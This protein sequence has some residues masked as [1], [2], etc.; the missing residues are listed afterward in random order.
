ML[1]TLAA[2]FPL[3]WFG[4]LT[5]SHGAGMSVPDWPNTFGYNMFAVRWDLWLGASAGGVFF[6]HTHRLLGSLVGVFAVAATLCAW[7]V[8]AEARARRWWS[9]S[10]TVFA[11]LA[12]ISF[13]LLRVD[14]GSA[15]RIYGHAASGFGGLALVACL[16][17][18][19]R[20]REPR[21]WV[22]WTT[23]SLLLA[24]IVQGILGGLR[25]TEV[26][27]HLAVA[28]GVFAQLTLCLCGFLAWATSASWPAGMAD[29]SHAS[30]EAP[31]R[32]QRLVGASAALTL[33]IFA[34]LVVA[35][36]MRHYDAGL[37]VPDFPLSFGQAVP[38]VSMTGLE[39]ANDIRVFQHE[40]PPT[41]LWQIWLHTAHRIGAT[42]VT[43]AAVWLVWETGRAKHRGPTRHV[44]LLVALL[45]AQIGLGIAT[46][47]MKKPADV[48]TG[49]VA[50]GAL[51]FLTSWLLTVRVGRL[52]GWRHRVA[53]DPSDH[54]FRAS[55][56]QRPR[57][58]AAAASRRHVSM[59][60]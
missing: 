28:H 3:I 58:R 30:A 48:A 54:A 13:V 4:G 12:A 40:L 1:V 21:R 44:F 53:A 56:A 2:M 20:C 11:A 37:A 41:S 6:E 42:A 36:M 29:A 18:L 17:W 45:L 49:H 9:G 33:L 25:V 59:S 32:L 8:G 43:L 55:I 23:T 34:Q 19:A 39:A 15:H 51:L 22:R 14:V 38:P 50:V 24:I 26:N 57:Q 5:T 35:A 10:A 46:V 47:W 52:Y 7:G 27:V 31:S 16:A 60:V